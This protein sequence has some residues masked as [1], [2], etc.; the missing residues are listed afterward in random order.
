MAAVISKAYKPTSLLL[1]LILAMN[2]LCTVHSVAQVADRERM[3][4]AYEQGGDLRGAARIYLELLREVP[5]SDRYFDG[6]V[7]TLS[8]LNQYESLLPIVLARLEERPGLSVA[9]LAAKTAIQAGKPATEYWTLAQRYAGNDAQAIAEIGV[10]QAN[11]MLTAQAIETFLAAR[12]ATGHTSSYAQQLQRLYA[13]AG[14][15]QESV[16]EVI[17]MYEEDGDIASAEGR[18]AALMTSDG[19]ASAVS[20]VLETY[21]TDQ[22]EGLR[23]RAWYLQHVGRW[24]EAFS[25]VQQIDEKENRRGQYILMFAD[26]A[27]RQAA[28]DVALQAYKS[29]MDR[30]PQIAL[31]AAFGYVQTLDQQ[32]ASKAT[33]SVSEARDIA[34]RY[35]QITR[36]Y[37]D[38]PLAANALLRMAE[39]ELD[40]LS[41][42][43]S[44]RDALTVLTN[45]WKGTQAA[46]EGA[47]LLADMYYMTGR[48]DLA[49]ELL[50]SVEVSGN[51]VSDLATLRRADYLL[52]DGKADSALR[53]YRALGLQ[54][55]SPASNDALTRQ[56]LLV[57]AMDDSIAV[58]RYIQGMAEAI[59]RNP[60]GAATSFASAASVAQTPE[61]A[62]ISN[63][64]AARF[65]LR[66]QDTAAAMRSLEPII[67]RI[68]ESSVGDR[69][70]ILVADIMEQQ[71]DVQGALSTL[72]TLLVQYPRSIFTPT[73]RARVRKLRGDV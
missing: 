70:L 64:E 41:D 51:V 49:M 40:Y 71:G 16:R 35:R 2:I 21:G 27:R 60:V 73:C 11:L 22:P 15:Y 55:Q 59:K 46:A 37:A 19:G 24:A 47:L 67:A 45:R 18:L 6:V 32:L 38:H 29:L 39:L 61:V 44:A 58:S 34:E 54:T 5:T 72:T 31:T 17:A 43:G 42:E 30:P 33:F 52:F 50:A 66:L 9:I 25:T 68:P 8:A 69:A 53:I 10:A 20:T 56:G 65:Y 48:F 12:R 7:R 4:V 36:Q 62:D 23:L 1:A 14:Q 3:A 13:I 63:L 57:M 28:Y 26:A